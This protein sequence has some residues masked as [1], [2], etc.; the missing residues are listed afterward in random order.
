MREPYGY[1]VCRPD[2]LWRGTSG[3]C[4]EDGVVR[5]AKDRDQG[6][7][8]ENMRKIGSQP[9]EQDRIAALPSSY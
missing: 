4:G 9:A 2:R 3:T 5:D 1:R 6:H 7:G 8:Y